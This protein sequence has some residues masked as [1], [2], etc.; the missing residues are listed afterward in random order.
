MTKLKIVRIDEHEP[1]TLGGI[2]YGRHTIWMEFPK[3]PW[4]K[5]WWVGVQ[6]WWYS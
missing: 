4:Y 5:R 2:H 1:H 3:T 6:I